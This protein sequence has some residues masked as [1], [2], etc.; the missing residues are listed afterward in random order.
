MADQYRGNVSLGLHF[1]GADA[2]TTFTELTGKTVSVFGNAQL[3]TAQFKYGTA[4][5]LFDGTGDYLTVPD[6]TDLEFGSGDFTIEAWVR[7]PSAPATVQSICSKWSSNDAVSNDDEYLFYYNG[8]TGNLRFDFRDSDGTTYRAASSAAGTISA[9]TWYHF[10]VSRNGNVF[11][12]YKD[13][14]LLG[15]TTLAFTIRTAS[16][17]L[18]IGRQ[19]GAS[20]T[21]LNGWLDDLRITKGVGRYPSAF[22]APTSAFEDT[23]PTFSIAGTSTLTPQTQDRVVSIAGTSTASFVSESTVEFAIAGTSSVSVVAYGLLE[24]SVAIAGTSDTS[25]R[26][27]T[28]FAIAGTA[29]VSPVVHGVINAAA[30]IA[31][32]SAVSLV[33]FSDFRA[34]FNIFGRG[35]LRPDVTY[36]KFIDFTIRGRAST[37]FK[38]SFESYSSFTINGRSLLQGRSPLQPLGYAFECAPQ[39]EASPWLDMAPE[40]TFRIRGRSKL[41]PRIPQGRCTRA[42]LAGTSS[43]RFVGRTIAKA[44]FSISG[45]GTSSWV[46]A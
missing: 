13:G 42:T 46:S 7:Y 24:T 33:S 40:A 43:A 10:A 37:S 19:N 45:S 5:G 36:E 30:T 39:F 20:P 1:D 3:D 14:S 23:G 15:Q 18:Y 29:T 9:N 27:G 31:G 35:E 44:A 11:S 17:P 8:S 34:R 12:L 4:A 6:T 22:T 26:A 2:S 38:S 16:N 41:K 32:T 25:F 28:R 21:Y